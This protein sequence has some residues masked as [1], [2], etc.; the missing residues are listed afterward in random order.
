MGLK[1]GP[2]SLLNFSF[3]PPAVGDAYPH[4]NSFAVV[5]ESTFPRTV[6][7]ICY[8]CRCCCRQE[9]GHTGA[10]DRS[11]SAGAS[12]GAFTATNSCKHDLKPPCCSVFEHQRVS[13]IGNVDLWLLKMSLYDCFCLSDQRK[14]F[15]TFLGTF[16]QRAAS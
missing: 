12:A 9:V 11:F 2:R 3:F 4:S 13:A 16:P 1:D 7:S 8:I 14:P 10:A 6:I 5:K 15:T